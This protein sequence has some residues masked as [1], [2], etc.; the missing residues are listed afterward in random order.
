MGEGKDAK[1]KR[2][3]LKGYRE[4]EKG[5]SRGK[6]LVSLSFLL[7]AVIKVEIF[8]HTSDIKC[9]TMLLTPTPLVT[10]LIP[11]RT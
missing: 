7:E 5:Y 9:Y 1:R 10:S 2:E 11:G 6:G 8:Y 3:P 4:Q